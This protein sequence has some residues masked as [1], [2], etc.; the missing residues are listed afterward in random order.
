VDWSF[1]VFLQRL[2][3]D[4]QPAYRSWAIEPGATA[5]EREFW[6]RQAV[7]LV[8]APLDREVEQLRAILLAELSPAAAR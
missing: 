3:P 4:E 8:D 1:R 6:R 7:E 2:W 5:L